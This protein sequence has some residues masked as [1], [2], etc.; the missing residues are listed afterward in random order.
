MSEIPHAV[1]E[2]QR[3]LTSGDEGAAKAM[4]ELFSEDGVFLYA[5][6]GTSEGRAAIESRFDTIFA[7]GPIP[8]LAWQRILQ[9]GDDCWVEGG[10]GDVTISTDHFTLGGD[11]RIT[12]LA[13]FTRR[14]PA[15]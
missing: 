13:V 4:A 9:A 14:P 8:S 6:G 3:I 15:S 10:L 11:G 2:Y 5:D 12:R 7:P 1:A